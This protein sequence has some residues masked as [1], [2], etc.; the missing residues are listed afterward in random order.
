[1]IKDTIIPE[2]E[3][4]YKSL[5]IYEKGKAAM[6]EKLYEEV[7]KSHQLTINKLLAVRKN[8]KDILEGLK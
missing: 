6:W 7:S 1:M 8:L 5:W 3:I 4:N 2:E